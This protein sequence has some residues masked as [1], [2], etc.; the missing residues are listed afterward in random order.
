MPAIPSPHLPP[1]NRNER[2]LTTRS[3]LLV[4]RLMTWFIVCGGL[5]VIAA[6][7]GI[8]VFI[9]HEIL[10]LFAGAQV[11]EAAIIQLPTA[12]YQALGFDEWGD[13]PFAVDNSGNIRFVNIAAETVSE[14]I[15][16]LTEGEGA[17]SSVVYNHPGQTVIIG[18]DQGHLNVVKIKYSATR[19]DDDTREVTGGI[20]PVISVDIGLPGNPLLAVDYADSGER[21]LAAAIQDQGGTPHV[22]LATLKQKRGLMGAGKITPGFQADLTDQIHGVPERVLVNTAGNSIVVVSN[23]GEVSYFYL[24]DDA[25]I[26]RQQF[27]P[28]PQGTLATID[29]L[30]GDVSLVCTD[31]TGANTIWSL[32]IHDDQRLFGQTKELTP[33]PTGGTWYAHSIRNKAFLLG[34]GSTISLRY[35]TTETIRW[36]GDIGFPTTLGALSGKYTRMGALDD[37]MR[38]HVYN[39]RDPHPESGI[40]SFFGKLWYEGASEPSY[41]WQSTGGTDDFEAKLSL[42]PLIIGSLK[43]A[44][45]ALLFAVPVAIVAAIY[46]AEF[47]RPDF[48][49]VVKPM[50]E[51]MASLPS[52]VLGF[53]AALWLAPKIEDQVPTIFCGVILIPLLAMLFGLFWSRLST[54][55]QSFIPRGWEFLALFVVLF[56]AVSLAMVIGPGLEW[57]VCRVPIVD[58]A[59]GDVTKVIHDFRLWWP[60]VTGTPFEQ[61]NSLVVGFIMGFAVIPIIYTISED[62]LSSVPPALRSGSLALGASR[63]QT[64]VRIVLPTAAAGIFSAAMIGFGRAVGETMIVVMATGNTAVMDWSI[65]TGMRT[66]SANIAVELPEAPHLSTLYRSLF[67]GAMVLFMLTFVV[68]TIAELMRQYLRERYKTV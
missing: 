46:S 24:E 5:A 19:N 25:F 10:P 58:Q 64:A 42:I 63:W 54:R 50:L 28:F 31:S 16:L 61:R 7:F 6:V 33:L 66:L 11:H 57:L 40:R 35:A 18:T 47:M 38:F 17:L 65:F 15:T 8:F 27:T 60:Y 52:V 34:A 67:L 12:K 3:T 55:T 56:V 23:A 21:K 36:Q 29:W 9:F 62:A 2:F 4:D 26:L 30:L 45:Y 22:V 1:S 43:G 68:N 49:R 39:V 53:L 20:E 14:P 51:L 44:F 59:T 13:L 48:K 32:Y 37:Q 41:T